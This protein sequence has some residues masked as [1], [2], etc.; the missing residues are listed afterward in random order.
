MINKKPSIY[1]KGLNIRITCIIPIKGRGFMNQR[2]GLR[3]TTVGNWVTGI[4]LRG[5]HLA[6]YEGVCLWGRSQGLRD[7]V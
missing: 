4:R 5:S 2:S 7:R 3:H 1:S 6:E